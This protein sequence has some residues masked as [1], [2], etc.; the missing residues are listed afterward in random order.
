MRIWHVGASSSPYRVDGVSRTVWSL[1]RQQGKLGH[2]V[3]L[4]I[5]TPPDPAAHQVAK[6]SN[7]KLIQV[8]AGPMN[9]RT[10]IRNIIQRE[11]PEV[12]HMHSVFVVRQATMAQVLREMNVPYVITPH[13]GLAPQVLRRGVI[14]KTLYSWL[15]ERPRFMGASAIALV[16][17]AEERAVRAYLP[18]FRNPVRWM[19]N[20]I[21]I[22]QVDPTRWAGVQEPKRV[23]FLG[24]FDVLV[25]GIDVLIE[26]ARLLP[27]IRFDLYGTEDPKTRDWLHKLKEHQPAN[28]H[29]NEPIFGSD[30]ARMLST[31]SIY[32]Q[33]SRWEGFP[34]SVAECLALGVPSAI[35]DTLDLAQLFNQ[36]DLGLVVPLDP[37]RAAAQIRSVLADEKRLNEWSERGKQFALEHFHPQVV[38]TNYIKLY[39]E[40]IDANPKPAMDATAPFNSPTAGSNGK[41]ARRK[42]NLI[43]AHFRSDLK[44]NVSML[45]QRSR[46]AMGTAGDPRTVVLCYH[47]VNTSDADLSIDPR[48]FRLQMQLLKDSGYEFL[49]FGD[50]V[51]RIMRWGPPRNNVACVTFDDGFE[52]NLTQ[53]APILS[54]LN[55]PAT[56]FV[57]TGLMTRDQSVLDRFLKLTRYNTTFL[58]PA[59]TRELSQAGF[60]IGAHTHTHRNLARLDADET[61]QEVGQSKQILE[62]TIG[63]RVRSFAY[64]FGKRGI[65][66]SDMT[67]A[68]VR[69][70][71]YGGAAAVAFRAV[72]ATSGI[73]IY[74]IPRFFVTRSDAPLA[75]TQKINGHYDWL[76]AIQQSTPTWLKSMVS[77]EDRY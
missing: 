33:P 77:P 61:W 12:V 53:A 23:V 47:S 29:F 39:Q 55:I 67:I 7:L 74:E 19:P 62:E 16:T 14:K 70:S 34:V 32:L 72:N 75:F 10:E 1:S 43:P 20:P 69:E 25:K 8:E 22:D 4:V 49:N 27:E 41:P 44:R 54:D 59:Q 31:A 46:Q 57:T 17:P 6:E 9:Y 51:S 66:Y 38:A 50:L 76:G 36:H 15:R 68:A 64:P 45:F 5:D 60:E 24:R 18:N 2:D 42:L 63:S 30:K 71:G 21:E 58:T 40:V 13:A 56:M 73:H 28:V 3:T 26:I 48:V 35:A 52:D 11:Q 65:H 37:P